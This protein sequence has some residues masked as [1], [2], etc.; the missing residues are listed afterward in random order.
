MKKF[1][2]AISM[3]FAGLTASAQDG[4]LNVGVNG[5]LPLGDAGD[6]Y[7]FALSAEANYLFEVSDKVA[8]GPS[9]SFINYFGKDLGGISIK[10]A[11]FLP[12]AGAARYGLT[13]EFSLGADVGYAVGISKG[14][15]GG[16]YYRPMIGYAVSDK[17]TVQASYTGISTDGDTTS[18]VGLGVMFNL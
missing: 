14:N 15:D 10:D 7:S 2:F 8:L 16:F 11:Q 6:A 18:N 13:D 17:V 1:I 5:L 3:A 12:V 4:S 9:V